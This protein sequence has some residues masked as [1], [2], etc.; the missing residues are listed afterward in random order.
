MKP[1]S[2]KGL[3]EW[4]LE[5]STRIDALVVF[6][7]EHLKTRELLVENGVETDTPS[8]VGHQYHSSFQRVAIRQ[9]SVSDDL[10]V[11][12]LEHTA[13]M[14]ICNAHQIVFLAADEYHSDCFSMEEDWYNKEIDQLRELDLVYL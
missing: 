6:E 4:L 14:T 3:L 9:V 13:A 1:K 8:F 10:I 12:I 2:K 11:V 5:Y 7:Y